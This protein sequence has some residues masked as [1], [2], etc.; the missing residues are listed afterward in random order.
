MENLDI[1]KLLLDKGA[2]VDSVDLSNS[3][4]LSYAATYGSTECAEILI[5]KGAKVDSVSIDSVNYVSRIPIYTGGGRTPLMRAVLSNNEEMV[6]FLLS[7]GAS[8]ECLDFDG[9]TA[10][11]LACLKRDTTL[12]GILNPEKSEHVFVNQHVD[13]VSNIRCRLTEQEKRSGDEYRK[14]IKENY[15]PKYPE[16]YFLNPEV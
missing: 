10:Y 11:D 3:T 4:P 1:I 15:I 5:E 14:I 7:K 9:R 16:L 12:A 2:A 6:R 8:R 13:I